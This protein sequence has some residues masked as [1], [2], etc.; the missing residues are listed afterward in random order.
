MH[1]RSLNV[2]NVWQHIH[3][4]RDGSTGHLAV[5]MGIGTIFAVRNLAIKNKKKELKEFQQYLHTIKMYFQV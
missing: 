4:V 1:N 2:K 3:W 5:G